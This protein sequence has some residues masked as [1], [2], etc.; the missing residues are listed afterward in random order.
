M[1]SVWIKRD[2]KQQLDSWGEQP[3]YKIHSLSELNALI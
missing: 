1:N 3:T 2:L